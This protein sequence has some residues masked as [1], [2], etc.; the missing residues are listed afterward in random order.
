MRH[1]LHELTWEQRKPV[2]RVEDDPNDLTRVIV[3][4]ATRS[5]ANMTISSF[6]ATCRLAEGAEILTM[7]L[8]A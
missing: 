4:D 3:T 7:R 2:T 6:L 5:R 1:N 8:I